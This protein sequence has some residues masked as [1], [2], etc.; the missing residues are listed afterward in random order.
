MLVV[1]MVVAL[2]MVVPVTDMRMVM[3]LVGV[4]MIIPLRL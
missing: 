1:D 2:V 3:V 4:I